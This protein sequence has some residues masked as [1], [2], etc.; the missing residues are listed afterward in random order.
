MKTAEPYLK[1]MFR[2]NL[3]QIAPITGWIR[4]ATMPEVRQY[5]SKQDSAYENDAMREAKARGDMKTYEVIKS[6]YQKMSTDAEEAKGP[7]ASEEEMANTWSSEINRFSEVSKLVSNPEFVGPSED[8]RAQ[9]IKPPEAAKP[10]AS[11]WATAGAAA[12]SGT[13]GT[14]SAVVGIAPGPDMFDCLVRPEG[15]TAMDIG[16]MYWGR[17]PIGTYTMS[18]QTINVKYASGGSKTVMAYERVVTEKNESAGLLWVTQAIGMQMDNLPPGFVL[19]KNA[20]EMKHD[21]KPKEAQKMGKDYNLEN[22]K[23]EECVV[24]I[25]CSGV[26][27]SVPAMKHSAITKMDN[28]HMTMESSSSSYFPYYGSTCGPLLGCDCAALSLSLCCY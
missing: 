12:A 3:L 15:H 4:R 14:A 8:D 24:P 18:K 7:S 9:Q 16:R 13:G 25:M 6:A 28:E 11:A 19:P 5:Y 27:Y 22:Q 21:I 23:W 26:L 20:T 17:Y 1:N 2:N 10:V